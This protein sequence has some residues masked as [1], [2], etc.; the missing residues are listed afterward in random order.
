MTDVLG[1]LT[2][3]LA[4][5][6]RI[7]RE[8]G[9]GGMATVYLAHDVRHDRKVALKV[10]RPELAAI[11]GG[12]RFLKEIRLTANLQHPH[13]LP[14]HDSGEAEGLVFYV[15]PYVEGESLRDRIT[16]DK[17]L[18]VAEAVRIAR[19]VADALD[20][21]HRHGIVHRD[22]KPENI[23][24]HDGH[25]AV[26]DFGIALAVSTAGGGTRMTE[27]GMSLGT[28]HYM[29]PEQAMGEREI[30]PRSDVYALGCVLYEM[31][32]GEP[33]YN[34]PTAQAIIARVMTEEP[35]GLTIQR[36]TIPPHVEAAVHTALAKLPADR[37]AS[38]ADFAAALDKA[39]FTVP[40]TR[41]APV[42]P[43]RGRP[44]A[45]AVLPW[46]LAALSLAVL[47]W[48]SARRSPPAVTRQRVIVRTGAFSPGALGRNAALAPDGGTIVF[49]DT[50]G[51][52]AQLWAK[53]PD[54]LDATLLAGTVGGGGPVF[55]PDGKWI[56]FV[57]D[58]KL[59]KVP[60]LGGSAITLSDS[61]NST[62]QVVAWLDNDSI[63]FNNPR[64]DLVLV[65]QDGGPVRTVLSVDTARH[66]ASGTLNGR[67][68]ISATG[69]PGGRGALVGT[70]APGCTSVDLRAVDIESGSNRV[71]VADVIKGWYV[72]TGQVVFVRQDGGVFAGAFDRKRRAF[73]GAPAPVMD[74][75]R[76]T[77]GRADMLLSG[78]G[79]LFYVPG[80]ATQGGA[81]VEP[82]WLTRTG[83]A[84]PVETGWS[85]IPSSNF[86]MALSPDGKRLA[87]SVRANGSED[88]WVKQLGRAMTRL[89]FSG[90]NIRPEWTADGKTVMYISRQGSGNED[91][92][93]RLADGTGGERTLLDLPR[94]IFE[95]VR[96]RDTSRII[97]RLG[98]PPS[99]DIFLF[100]RGDTVPRPLLANP[101]AEEV[102][103]ALSPDGRWLAYASNESGRYEIYVRPFPNVDAGRWQVSRDGGTEPVWAHSGRELFFRAS[104]GALMSVAVTPG[105]SFNA[106][107][108]RTLFTAPA[109]IT[110]TNRQGY[111]VSPDDQRFLFLRTLGGTQAGPNYVVRV[112]QWLSDLRGS[113]G[114]R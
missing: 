61:A 47:A 84:T 10:L 62:Y 82:V 24:L 4:D 78:N 20:Y 16:R 27:T 85:V 88:I 52:L 72:G 1:R 91:L 97:V 105:A 43:A 26:A 49:L 74:G 23:L 46:A 39:D 102:T 8:L 108:P 66:G 87:M 45:Q 113:N 103:P 14:L 31:L 76:T 36:K 86:G 2:T 58:G 22:I 90:V 44:R 112:D 6:Y 9:A 94:P 29:S 15:M 68:V 60:R 32:V 59:K 80:S 13:I 34:G 93:A 50:I 96:T 55:S 3:S 99:R 33:P 104:E 73:K 7:E 30:T 35:R 63:L 92:H 70:C 89:T 81:P 109:L 69:L 5:R 37:F 79:T 101:T 25:V 42:P 40:A 77:P 71:L 75:V 48:N 107:S 19:E 21:A 12:E 28:P 11:L 67:G 106:A 114:R 18:P 64:Y 57:A 38:A 65:H 100:Q 95:I 110:G 41:A 53:D 111:V 17:Q 98:T 83:A 56:A 54:R 51:G